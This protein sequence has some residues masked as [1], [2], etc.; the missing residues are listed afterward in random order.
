MSWRT[1][2]AVGAVSVVSLGGAAAGV[3]APGH[4]HLTA[5]GDFAMTANTTAVLQGMAAAAPD[6]H[7]ALGDLSYG[8]T[9][10]EQK[11][12]DL[13]TG[14]LGAGA[15]FELVSGN[16]E[17]NGQNGNI[18]D[19]SACLPNQLPGVVGTYGRQYYVDLPRANPLVRVVMISPALPF[20]DGTW[21]YAKGSAR[22]AWTA[23]AIDGARSAGIPWVVVGMHKPCLSLGEYACDPGPD[24]TN[25]LLGKKV[26]LVLN[27]HEHLYQRTKQLR[28]SAGC[29]ALVVGSVDPDCISDSDND[30]VAG[31]GTVFATVGT[32]GQGLR[33]ITTT[34]PELGYFAAYEGSNLTP[35]HG[36]GDL[37]VTAD[38]LTYAFVPVTGSFTDGFT[39]TKVAGPAEV[40]PTAAFVAPSDGLT[41]H[42]DASGSTD[43]DGT[44]VAWTWDFGDGTTGSG[45]LLDHTFASGGTYP[46][47][48]T[49]LDDDG[50]TASTTKNVTVS[51][52]G[53]VVVL[54]SDTFER[55]VTNG[56]GTADVGGAWTTSTSAGVAAVN[57][58]LGRLNLLTAGATQTAG[59]GAVSSSDVDLSLQLAV[60]KLPGGSTSYVDASLLLRRVGTAQYRAI[61]RVLPTGG[62]R[63]ALYRV[64]GST[65]A[66]LGGLLTVPGITYAP[67]DQLNVR[68]RA[69]GTSPTT[70]RLKVWR[71]GT[72]EP[73]AWLSTVQDA[74]AGLQAAGSVGLM[75]YVPSA[76]TNPPVQLR[77][78]ALRA[79]VGSTVP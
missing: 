28:L 69:T 40:A 29:T 47:T 5:A 14:A 22:Y 30:L 17:S 73:T 36:Y 46:V 59:L 48:L 33:D 79:A 38:T 27:G 72:P 63:G 35:S 54:A 50:L 12:C 49:V 37:D 67:G 71:V 16:H 61:V 43:P 2:L 53:Q 45:A 74:T 57:G 64:V 55:T 65:G 41:A 1:L 42:L 10:E 44:V 23:A 75:G 32:G 6:A 20:P 52:A 78:D 26:D 18:N 9:G 68:A 76:T 15:P 11:F 34:D 3:T 8:V 13:V 25:L 70:L 56:W 21:D 39:L 66:T 7:L 31:G 62:V 51:N 77:F 60:D 19:F 24:I 58:G 4:V